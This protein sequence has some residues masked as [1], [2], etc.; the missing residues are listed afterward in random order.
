MFFEPIYIMMM[1]PAILLSLT[2]RRMTRNGALAGMLA[3][4]VTVVVW[5]R[6]SGGLFDVYE[7][8]PGF[9]AG[10][11]AIIAVSLC[12]RPPSVA[13]RFFSD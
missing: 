1:A 2:W 5:G 12:G 3:G 6:M 8:L 11:L 4:A 9:I 13:A 7:I 10:M